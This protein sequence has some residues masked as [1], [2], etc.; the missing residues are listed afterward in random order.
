MASPSYYDCP[1]CKKEGDTVALK[2]MSDDVM[3][4]PECD[5]QRPLDPNDKIDAERLEDASEKY[6]MDRW[7]NP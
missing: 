5:F 2:A 6:W 3:Y 7:N 1:E 4:C